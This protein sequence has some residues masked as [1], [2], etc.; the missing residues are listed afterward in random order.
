MTV[1]N[2]KKDTVKNG[3]EGRC[4]TM[5]E[6]NDGATTSCYTTIYCNVTTKVRA[7]NSPA[8]ASKVIDCNTGKRHKEQINDKLDLSKATKTNVAQCTQ[9]TALKMKR[10]GLQRER[11]RPKEVV[12]KLRGIYDSALFYCCSCSCCRSV[13][14]HHI[15]SQLFDICSAVSQCNQQ[16]RSWVTLNTFPS[17]LL[18][19]IE[20][21]LS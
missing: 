20:M 1:T 17:L 13:T 15:C 11:E 10:N 4:R 8:N 21:L 6:A 5:P 16:T 14:E 7:K 3:I 9:A 19:D 18:T 2:N 12:D